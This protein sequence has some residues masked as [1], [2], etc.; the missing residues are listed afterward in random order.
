MKREHTVRYDPK[1]HKDR[2]DWDRV[3]RLTDEDIAKAVAS[4]PD[5]APLLTK[6]W[7]EQAQLIP[8]L[9]KKKGV[10][11]RLDQEVVDWFKQQG[12]RYQTR[13]NAVLRS[14][15]KAHGSLRK[16]RNARSKAKT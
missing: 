15:M 8:P 11:L 5:A 4:D 12:P 9:I 7:F 16:R 13:M 14:F 3:R 6:E 2:T 10:Y 1:K